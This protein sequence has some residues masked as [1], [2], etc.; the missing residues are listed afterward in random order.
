M[1]IE[2]NA[3]LELAREF[4]MQSEFILPKTKKLATLEGKRVLKIG[5]PQAAG[6]WVEEDCALRL[7]HI[8]HPVVVHT[9]H[10]YVH[11]AMTTKVVRVGV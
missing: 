11:L 4:R 3:I 2:L 6:N 1:R 5:L 9:N 8:R 7:T 10:V